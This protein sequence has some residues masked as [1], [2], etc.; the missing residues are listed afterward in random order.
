M[1]SGLPAT[2][3]GRARFC[4]ADV[5]TDLCWRRANPNASWLDEIRRV[6]RERPDLARDLSAQ[7]ADDPAL[8]LDRM[9]HTPL[10]LAGRTVGAQRPDAEGGIGLGHRAFR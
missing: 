1:P 3:R 7:V 8:F 10:Y 2:P 6:L 5:F 9:M 4:P